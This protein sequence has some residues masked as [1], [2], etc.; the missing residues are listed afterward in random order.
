VT[1]L[2]FSEFYE[3][4]GD[5]GLRFTRRI[6]GLDGRKVRILGYIVERQAPVPGTVLLTPIPVRLHEHEA[7]HADDLPAASVFVTVPDR[8]GEV[9]PYTP[10][11]FLLTGTLQLGNHEEVDGRVS[12][13]R[14]ILDPPA[15]HSPDGQPAPERETHR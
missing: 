11:L 10:G 2:K 7:G 9:V 6:L 12:S 1:D 3:T 8:P 15:T 5:R 4:I 14:L 13:V